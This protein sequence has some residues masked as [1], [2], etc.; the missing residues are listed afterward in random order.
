M[1]YICEKQYR[2]YFKLK[3]YKHKTSGPT[4]RERRNYVKKANQDNTESVDCQTNL[5]KTE[6]NYLLIM[7]TALYGGF[8]WRYGYCQI[9]KKPTEKLREFSLLLG[10]PGHIYTQYENIRLVL[11]GLW[12]GKVP[13]RDQVW[14]VLCCGWQRATYRI[15]DCRVAAA[16]VIASQP[17]KGG[18]QTPFWT[19]P[20]WSA[21]LLETGRKGGF[22]C[23][24]KQRIGEV[25]IYSFD[26]V[27]VHAKIRIAV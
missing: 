22:Q 14:M 19:P 10:Q 15:Q 2:Q 23:D 7:V 26:T 24:P 8:T 12:K 17:Q 18:D 27:Q 20:A 5:Q 1:N 25:V 3:S 11:A 4:T 13:A 16:C 6:L 9:Y 21:F